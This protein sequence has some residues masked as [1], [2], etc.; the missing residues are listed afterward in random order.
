MRFPR[1]RTAVVVIAAVGLAISS[2]LTWRQVGTWKD[3]VTLFGRAIR[4]TDRN[5]MAHNNLGIA[6]MNLGRLDEAIEQLRAACRAKPDLALAYYNL[7]IVYTKPGVQ[8]FEEAARQ[9]ELATRY[10]EDYGQAFN[11][12]ARAY[13]LQG[14][15]EQAIEGYRRAL[16]CSRPPLQAAQNLAW[17]LATTDDTALRDGDEAVRWAEHYAS[18]FGPNLPLHAAVTLAAAHAQAGDFDAAVQWQTK[19]IALAPESEKEKLR[20]HLDDYRAGSPYRGHPGG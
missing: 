20:R 3:N 5:Y 6:Y 16:A 2:V 1:A 12:L 9:F 8:D 15:H 13:D 18:A 7:G 10:D 14:K 11:N 17:L 19:A 4:V